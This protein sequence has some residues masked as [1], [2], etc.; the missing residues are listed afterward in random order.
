MSCPTGSGWKTAL[1][2]FSTNIDNQAF[3]DAFTCLF[4]STTPGGLLVI[5]TLVWFG[6]IAMSYIRSGGS[7]A[8]PVVYTLLFGGAVLAQ[9]ATPVLGM[10]SVL[11]LGAFAL[12]VVL[13]AR[14][15]ETA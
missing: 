3:V 10:A 7:L 1:D 5:G 13:V 9:V 14:R 15:T 6:V 8:M 2:A 12:V 4:A 11:L